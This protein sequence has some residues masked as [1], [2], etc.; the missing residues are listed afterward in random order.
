VQLTTVGKAIWRGARKAQELEAAGA[1]DPQVQE[2]LEKLK[3]VETFWTYAVLKIPDK[4]G[5]R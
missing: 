2:R 3:Q 5:L 1:G 4:M